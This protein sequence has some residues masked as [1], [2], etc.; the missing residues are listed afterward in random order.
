M[1]GIADLGGSLFFAIIVI[2][3]VVALIYL[4]MSYIRGRREARM[5]HVQLYFDEHFRDVI[6]EWDLIKRPRVKEW[7]VDISKRL[8]LV[9]KDIDALSDV[10]KSLDSRLEKL[11]S[12]INKLE[13]M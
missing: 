13:I 7:Q 5:E 8:S 6:K 11:D 9:G 12:E 3:L 2:I 10:R 1:T 4:I